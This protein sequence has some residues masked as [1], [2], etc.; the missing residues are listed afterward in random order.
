MILPSAFKSLGAL[1][2]NETCLSALDISVQRTDKIKCF[3]R[4]KDFEA[5]HLCG[6]LNVAEI[7]RS[8]EAL[9]CLK[10]DCLRDSGL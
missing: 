3:C 8:K 2:A 9:H 4:S 5:T 1:S 10:L 6:C 7:T